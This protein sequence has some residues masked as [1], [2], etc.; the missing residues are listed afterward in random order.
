MHG[1]MIVKKKIFIVYV[2]LCIPFLTI[3]LFGAVIEP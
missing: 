3:N 2:V 1:H